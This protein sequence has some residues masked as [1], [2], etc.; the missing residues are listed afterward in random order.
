MAGCIRKVAE[1]AFDKA[2]TANV[3]ELNPEI[4]VGAGFRGVLINE[5]NCRRVA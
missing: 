2:T 5:C 4:G 1:L 3:R